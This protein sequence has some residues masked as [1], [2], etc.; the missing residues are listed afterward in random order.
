MFWGWELLS[1][2]TLLKEPLPPCSAQSLLS[3][4]PG[5][6]SLIEM[7]END[8][9]FQR[10]NTWADIELGNANWKTCWQNLGWASLLKFIRTSWRKQNSV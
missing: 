9:C 6:K 4:S 10:E 5:V 7:A 1:E 3:V 8:M 2:G